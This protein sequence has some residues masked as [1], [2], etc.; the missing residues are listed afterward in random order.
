MIRHLRG[1]IHLDEPFE[2]A[3][4]LICRDSMAGLSLQ[5]R[6]VPS[7]STFWAKHGPKPDAVSSTGNRAELAQA[8]AHV[9][10]TNSTASSDSDK[11]TDSDSDSLKDCLPLSYVP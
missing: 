4:D 9:S 6:L 7:N 11:V 2:P 1:C 10:T 8:S 3:A 5:R